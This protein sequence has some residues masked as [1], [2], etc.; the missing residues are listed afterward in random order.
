MA[1]DKLK[2]VFESLGFTDVQPFI[3][4]GN[5]IFSS[6]TKPV[7]SHIEQAIEQQL[8]FFRP[9][10]IRSQPEIGAIIKLAPFD[11]TGHSQRYYT[12]VTFLKTP[13]SSLPF[14]VPLHNADNFFEIVHYDKSTQTLFTVTDHTA[15]KTPKVMAWLEKQLGNDITSRTWNTVE[16]IYSKL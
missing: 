5:V 14:S 4:S 9:I 15:V 13:P 10:C 1:N 7:E 12:L 6:A 8:G 3:S 2:L 11:Q 16:R